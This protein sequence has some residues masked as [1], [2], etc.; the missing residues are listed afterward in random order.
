MSKSQPSYFQGRIITTK[1]GV[2]SF[3]EDVSAFSSDLSLS[4]G[5]GLL[6]GLSQTDLLYLFH[7]NSTRI[8]QSNGLCWQVLQKSNL[9]TETLV[10]SL[11][12]QRAESGV[13]RNVECTQVLVP[14]PEEKFE[15]KWLE[16]GTG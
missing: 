13:S 6:L 8:A 10:C 2:M 4:S 3:T 12:L 9:V 11:A 5:K 7:A 14:S 15:R 1:S 16:A